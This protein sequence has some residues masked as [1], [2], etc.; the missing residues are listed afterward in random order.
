MN[1]VVVDTNVY[2]DALRGD[3]DAM[4]VLQTFEQVLMSPIVVGE[5]RAGFKGGKH[6][7]VNREQLA[8][9]L[10]APRVRMTGID[11]TTADYY[12]LIV[13]ELRKAGSPIP[14]NDVWIAASALQHGARL[15]TR[16]RHFLKV[17]GLLLDGL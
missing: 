11:E 3:S 6:E 2:C 8:R 1:S 7:K 12:A 4:A 5:L 15:A 13:D 17:P 9:F 10:A 14:T 16:D